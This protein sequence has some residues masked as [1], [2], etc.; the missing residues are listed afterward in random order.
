MVGRANAKVGTVKLRQSITLELICKLPASAPLSVGSTVIVELIQAR[1]RPTYVPVGCVVSP[2]WGD[3]WVPLKLINPSSKAVTLRNCKIADVFLCVAVEELSSSERVS[4]NNHGVT[5]GSVTTKFPEQRKD[6]L[7]KVGLQE[8][9]FDGC[10]VSDQWKDRL[11]QL[12]EKYGSIFSQDK[13]DFGEAMDVVHKINLMD[14]RLF[15]LPYRPI[16]PSQYEMLR[17]ALNEMEE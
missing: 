6:A 13:K 14:Q 9:D 15:C 4:V 10:K 16:P 5:Q 3:R 17:T 11:L 2:L 12:V 1:S 8:L 7:K